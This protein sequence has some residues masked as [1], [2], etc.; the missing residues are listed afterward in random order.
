MS[1]SPAPLELDYC[2][3]RVTVHAASDR[4]QVVTAVVLYNL[5]IEQPCTTFTSSWRLAAP[6]FGSPT[7]RVM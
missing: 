6:F 5:D 3:E 4:K 7:D 2:L 1:N